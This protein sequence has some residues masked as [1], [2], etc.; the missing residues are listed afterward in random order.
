MMQKA[1]HALLLVGSPKG[2][3]ST[4]ESLGTY[5]LSCLEKKGLTTEKIY[6]HR[7]INTEDEQKNLLS[8]IAGADLLIL[9]FPLYIDSL[10]APVIQAME[11][12]ELKRREQQNSREI[13]FIAI[14]NC[15]FPESSQND[16]A[17]KICRI[18]AQDAGFKWM[19]GLA[20]GMG[21]GIDGKPLEK[22]GGLVRHI[23][24]GLNLAAESLARRSSIPKEAIDLVGK[25][26]IPRWMYV[27]FGNLGW[28]MQARKF[29]ARRKLKDQPYLEK[30]K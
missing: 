14:A 15:G 29:G 19:G 24:K 3:K 17:L 12:I 9:A 11:L 28:K 2:P 4:S 26:A 7:V 16:T 8:A 6:I 5:L 25:P 30:E 23:T 1:D 27:F 10:P 22:S 18:F 13:Q 20:I 21:G